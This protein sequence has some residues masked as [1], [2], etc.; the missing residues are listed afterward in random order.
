MKRVYNNR[1][2]HTVAVL[3]KESDQQEDKKEEKSSKQGDENNTE[4]DDDHCVPARLHF[5]NPFR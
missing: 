4:K 3:Y 2:L 1:R 5:P